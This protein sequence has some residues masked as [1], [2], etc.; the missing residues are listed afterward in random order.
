MRKT[1][2]DLFVLYEPSKNELIEMLWDTAIDGVSQ[3]RHYSANGIWVIKD[4]KYLSKALK[5]YTVIDRVPEC[6]HRH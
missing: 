2:Y 3:W 4:N 5:K 6:I 1:K